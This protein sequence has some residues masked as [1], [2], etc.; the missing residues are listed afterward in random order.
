MALDSLSGT[1]I[2]N[3][4]ISKI[5]DMYYWDYLDSVELILSDK[6]EVGGVLVQTYQ[7]LIFLNGNDGAE[8]WKVNMGEY[9]STIDLV[10]V[11]QDGKDEIVTRSS[12]SL[13]CIDTPEDCP[14]FQQQPPSLT[15]PPD[16]TNKY[17][18][19]ILITAILIGL[20][21]VIVWRISKHKS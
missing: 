7:E 19:V 8:M 14:V 16:T 3:Y 10:D 2:W 6:Y 21:V 5:P 15:L 4:S 9:T 12:H 1:E 20:A 17:V 11:D 13:Y 18:P